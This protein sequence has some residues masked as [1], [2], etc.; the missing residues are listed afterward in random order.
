MKSLKSLYKVGRG[1]SS[2]HTMGP[3]AAAARFKRENPDADRFRAVLMGSLAMTGRGHGTDRAV[4]A[5]LAPAEA[6]ILFDETA[7]DLPHPNTMIL[8]GYT[9]GVKTASS[10]VLSIGGGDVVFLGD[11][12]GGR[13]EGVYPLSTL[14]EIKEHCRRMGIPLSGYAYECEGTGLRDFLTGIWGLMKSEIEEGLSRSGVLP[15]GL[16]VKRKAAMLWNGGRLDMRNPEDFNRAVCA[17]AYAAGEQNASNGVVVTAPTCG[18]CGV[19]PA[20]LYALQKSKDCS[21]KEIADALASAGIIGNIIRTNASISGA[22]CGCQAE[23]GSAC[24][25]AAAAV[26]SLYGMGLDE[27]ESAAEIAMEHHL[28]LTCDPV[29]GL[30]QIPCIERNAVAAVDALTAASLA[31][32]LTSTQKVS[33][34]TVVE[35]MY[36]TG[37]DLGT[38]YRETSKGGLAKLYGP[39]S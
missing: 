26:A 1:P 20:V 18:S 39:E 2:S 33:F 7:L 36:E 29:G 17:F 8:E 34:D 31:K 3:A 27:T 16:G 12:A 22:E 21:D 15:G 6:E 11:E 19:V 37:K 25:M 13:E 4:A 14:K 10:T 38:N 5:E 23:I 28:G 24:S 30:V 9:G 35:T 32:Y